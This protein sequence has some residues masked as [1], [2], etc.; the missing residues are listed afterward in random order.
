MY[1]KINI[2]IFDWERNFP[3]LKVGLVQES[4]NCMV[5]QAFPLSNSL[6]Y[7]KKKKHFL[8]G[9]IDLF[10]SQSDRKRGAQGD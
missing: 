5:T 7:L 1:D 8:K 10:E 2:Y 3:K 4:A 6:S 9:F